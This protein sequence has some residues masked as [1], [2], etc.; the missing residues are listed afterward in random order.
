[1]AQKNLWSIDPKAGGGA[2]PIQGP[3]G[4]N[5]AA[6]KKTAKTGGGGGAA[7]RTNPATMYHGWTNAE[8][9]SKQW[10]V[11]G[12]LTA[13]AGGTGGYGGSAWQFLHGLD[14]SQ[15]QSVFGWLGKNYNPAQGQTGNIA[16]AQNLL[17]SGNYADFLKMVGAGGG[18][19]NPW[20]A[21]G[22]GG[23]TAPITSPIYSNPGAGGG[24]ADISGP[25]PKFGL[26]GVSEPGTTGGWDALL[27][28]PGGTAPKYRGLPE[29]PQ[30]TT[31]GNSYFGNL[32]RRALAKKNQPY[33][34]T[35]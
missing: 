22:G 20:A 28:G 16:Q 14:P 17:K 3:G 19:A 8:D 7:P 15:K 23:G 26:P 25:I 6:K 33:F 21:G 18:Q 24:A 1:M 27:S 29:F 34:G 9:P 10:G 31:S 12:P 30:D 11:W 13:G 2:A 4:T 35:Y 32:L 5:P